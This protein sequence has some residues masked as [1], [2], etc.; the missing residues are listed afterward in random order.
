MRFMGCSGS[1]SVANGV[2]V[3]RVRGFYTQRF[4]KVAE[5]V[6][7]RQYSWNMK[8]NFNCRVINLRT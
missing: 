6:D 4:Q 3:A 1:D 2:S 8:S 7:N 5:S